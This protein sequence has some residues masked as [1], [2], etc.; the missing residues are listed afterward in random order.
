MLNLAIKTPKKVY[1]HGK[2]KNMSKD[3]K[4]GV[5]V[6]TEKKGGFSTEQHEH[7]YACEHRM[8]TIKMLKVQ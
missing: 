4:E 7:V 2:K 3:I 6:L 8:E 1:K 5:I